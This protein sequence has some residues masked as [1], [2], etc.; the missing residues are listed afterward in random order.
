MVKEKYD[1]IVIGGGPAGATCARILTRSGLDVLVIEKKDRFDDSKIGLALVETKVFQMIS[2]L[3][4]EL[5]EEVLAN[6]STISGPRIYYDNILTIKSEN[7]QK[8]FNRAELD[9]QMLKNCDAEV[10][11]GALFK[12]FKQNEDEVQVIYEIDGKDYCTKCRYLISAQG[13]DSSVARQL[14]PNVLNNTKKCRVRQMVLKG[15]SVFEEGYYY[16]LLNKKSFLNMLLPKNGK[17]YYIIG[18]NVDEDIDDTIAQAYQNLKDN[19]SFDGEI[20]ETNDR[21]VSDLWMNPVIGDNNILILGESGG[22]WGQA[23][24]I[25]YGILTAKL[26]A[27][28]VIDSLNNHD[29]NASALYQ[30]R[31]EDNDIFKKVKAAHGNVV[32]MNKFHR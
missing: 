28:A 23:D 14:F 30:K 5:T 21:E 22:I 9:T 20:V 19:Y 24:G 25:Y 15:K 16:M 32:L 2:D 8:C 10:M 13:H 17:I 31:L 6:P 29:I 26:C 4:P 3:F 7:R 1:V 12:K 18:N 11:I 27:E